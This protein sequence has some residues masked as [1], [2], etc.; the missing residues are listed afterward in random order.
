[1]NVFVGRQ[2]ILD[3]DEN[4][5]AYELLYRN[6]SKNSFPEIDADEATIGLI[7][8]TFMS[9]G[10]DVVNKGGL[11]FINFTGSLLAKEVFNYLDPKLVVIEILEDVEITPSL[12][13]KIRFMKDDG[14]KIAMDDFI[15][16]KQYKIHASLF[17]FINYIKVDF[18]SSSMKERLII[19][20]FAVKYPHI[21]LIAEKVETME[22]YNYAKKSG[23]KLF[24]GYY[25]AQPE[26]ISGYEIP[27]RM[28]LHFQIIKRLSEIE[29]DIASIAEFIKRDVSLSY[30]LLRFIN[31]AGVG[32]PR[33]ISSI[34]QAIMVIGINGMKKWMHV[35]TLR[36]IGN[37][38]ESGRVKALVQYSLTRAKMCELLA[39]NARKKNPESY[40]LAGMFSLMDVITSRNWHDVLKMLPLSDEVTR[41]LMGMETEIKPY[42][43]LS[44]AVERFDLEKAKELSDELNI[45]YSDLQSFTQTSNHWIQLLD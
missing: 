26:V 35:L 27:T 22:D 7:V 23:Y 17:E 18:L 1:V 5:F 36:D 31:S 21:E 19:E 32:M 15:M 6:S 43:A 11:S 39:I 16:Q 28:N 29:P 37:N 41:T 38:A 25:F 9:I 14:F 12:I 33:E 44:I 24:Q 30:K 34:N 2:P 20:E 8:N 42:L 13:T 3:L 4:I 45:S 10:I 40:F